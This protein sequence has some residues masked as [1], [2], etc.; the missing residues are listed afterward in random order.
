MEPDRIS[1]QEYFSQLARLVAK[2]S[3]CHRLHV[4]CVLVKENHIIST[5][6]N[7]FLPGAEHKSIVV[8]GHELATVHAEMNAVVDCAR[9]GVSVDGAVAYITHY[10]C[11][12]C[13]KALVAA[14]VNKILYL[15]DYRNNEVVGK[16]QEGCGVE[17]LKIDS[18][19]S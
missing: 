11:V 6:Y 3:P 9:R 14:G 15:E 12:N 7:G 19:F 4:G 16:L 18:P 17:V 5:G 13:F 2:R 1:W 8:D 10:P